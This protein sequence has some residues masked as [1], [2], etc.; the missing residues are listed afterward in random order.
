MAQARIQRVGEDE[1]SDA[2]PLAGCMGRCQNALCV[3]NLRQCVSEPEEEEQEQS[4]DS[5][6]EAPSE[7]ASKDAGEAP[8]KDATAEDKNAKAGEED[9]KQSGKDVK[10]GETKYTDV[11]EDQEG[12]DAFYLPYDKYGKKKYEEK[13]RYEY[14]EAKE[15]EKEYEKKEEEKDSDKDLAGYKPN[16]RRHGLRRDRYLHNHVAL[17][18]S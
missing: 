10:E 17:Q 15:H 13:K 16:T 3:V 6:K 18:R 12:D 4:E 11:K 9:A 14:E 8:A 7:E 1:S 2:F 5:A